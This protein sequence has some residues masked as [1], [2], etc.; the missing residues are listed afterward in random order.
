LDWVQSDAPILFDHLIGH[1]ANGG[2]KITARP[3]MS[4]PVPLSS[5]AE[6]PP[7]YAFYNSYLKR[8]AGLAHQVSCSLCYFTTRHF[9]TILGYP[10]KMVLNLINRMAAISIVHC[11]LLSQIIAAKADRL[12]PVV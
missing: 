8:F 9:V 12:K 11:H 5:S 3:K 4:S 1:L 7:H 6:T 10:N 2:A